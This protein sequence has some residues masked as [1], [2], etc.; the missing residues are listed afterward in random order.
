MDKGQTFTAF[1][2]QS[3]IA[4]GSLE[5]V[6]LKVKARFDE[7]AS[8]LPLIFEDQTSYQVD[9]DLRG[10]PSEV[11]AKVLPAKT[12]SGPGRPRLGVVSR[13]VSLLPR[14]WSWLQKQPNGASAALRR[15]VDEA[16][17]R[18]VEKQERD[19]A[20]DVASRFM[21]AMAGDLPGYEEAVRSLYAG[22]YE[23]FQ[24]QIENWPVD[25]RT[26]ITVL[27]KNTFVF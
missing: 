21:S 19:L 6:L 12:P 9:F 18:D 24:R 1:V 27:T 3:L 7:D 4:S 23:A 11:L 16:K 20:K 14:H 25:I 22:N 5:S 17:S 13:E 8:L 15:L 10:L 26:H 2:G